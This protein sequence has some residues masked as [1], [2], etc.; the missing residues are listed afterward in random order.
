MRNYRGISIILILSLIF[1]NFFP[2]FQALAESPMAFGEIKAA[3]AVLIESSTGK[4]VEMRDI[5]P[6]LK[7]TKLR[8]GDGIVFITTKDGSKLDLSRETE[9]AIDVLNGTYTVKLINGTLSFNITPS[10]SFTIVTK[11]ANISVTRQMDGYYSLIAGA[12]APGFTNIQ[13]M[14]FCDAKGTYIRS[15]A[16]SLNISGE[17]FQP[18]ILSTGETF[19]ASVN[20]SGE[21][22]GYTTANPGSTG[23][24]PGLIV[25]VVFTGAAAIIASESFREEEVASPS[26][27]Q[28]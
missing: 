19:L 22:L 15:I 7:N 9:V 23:L 11:D 26:G 6:L 21:P 17:N 18:K 10:A 20:G 16:G 24:V 8:T 13:G 1:T 27:F 14:V 25:G 3:G 5:Y 28:F 2:A 4:W 12:G